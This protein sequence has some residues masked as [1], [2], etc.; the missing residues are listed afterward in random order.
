[1][2]F[3]SPWRART[4]ILQRPQRLVVLWFFFLLCSISSAS[5]SSSSSDSYASVR[6]LDGFGNSKQVEYAQQAA[7]AGGRLVLVAAATQDDESSSTIVVV[8][9]MGT[10]PLVHRISLHHPNTD[11][12]ETDGMLALCGVG[13]QGDLAWLVHQLRT[14]CKTIWERYDSPTVSVSSIAHVVSHLMSRFQ[15]YPVQDELWNPLLQD[16]SSDEQEWARPL[17]LD[18]LLLSTT[19]SNNAMLRVDPSG[20]IASV[21]SVSVTSNNHQ[22]ISY[23]ALGTKHSEQIQEQLKTLLSSRNHDEDSTIT[24][25]ESSSLS[26]LQDQLIQVLL[27]EESQ[28]YKNQVMHVMVE[29]LTGTQLQ[30]QVLYFQ[31]GKQIV[32]KSKS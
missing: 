1:M 15:G 7:S 12:A 20:S 28:N 9:S 32:R 24:T 6:A 14:Y 16:S 8:V 18:V 31:N 22:R 21:P 3:S 30:Q 26:L 17:G 10:T 13:F 23:V 19:R 2:I 5:A 29:T 11:H 27:L 25:T 4:S